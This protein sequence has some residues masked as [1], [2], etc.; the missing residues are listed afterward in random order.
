MTDEKF[1]EAYD[2]LSFK[3]REMLI[4]KNKK[5]IKFIYSLGIFTGIVISSLIILYLEL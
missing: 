2:E 3:M 1:K 4:E 5:K